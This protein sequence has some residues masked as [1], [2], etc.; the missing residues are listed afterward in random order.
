MSGII[1]IRAYARTSV[2][3]FYSV[4][5]TFT[6]EI[7]VGCPN[8]PTLTDLDGNTYQTVQIGT[9]C[10]TQSNLK[11]SKYRNG[12]NIP[13]GLSNSAWQN[14]T[15]GAY[16][17]YDN[18]PV[19]DGLYG[20][21]YNHFAV[22]DLRGL[23]PV[24]WHVPT[25]GDWTTLENFLGGSVVAGGSLKSTATL[26]IP[27][28]WNPPNT[29]S[30]NLVGFMAKPGGF[31]HI[32]A[33]F[34]ALGQDG[35]WWSST[36]TGTNASA[37]RLSNNNYNSFLNA[38][39]RTFGFSVRCLRDTL[40]TFGSNLQ[41][42]TIN[43]TAHLNITTTSALTGGLIVWDGGTPI[44][45]RGVVYD[46]MQNS[47]ISNFVT[48]VGS[49]MGLF[50]N[51]LTGLIPSKQYYYRAF[52]T[53]SLGTSYG[54]QIQFETNDLAVGMSY[55]GGI[56]FYLDTVNRYGLMCAPSDQGYFRWGCYGT[57]INNTSSSIGSGATNTTSIVTNCSQ[58]PIAASI[59]SDLVLNGY[60][61]W[62]LPSH[63]ELEM[64]Y[65]RLHQQGIG[66][67]SNTAYYWSSTQISPEY[68]ATVAFNNS[69]GN[70]YK[71]AT[72]SVR[73]VR[74]FFY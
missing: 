40:A 67:F 24:G 32:Y 31:N 63:D 6:P 29:G 74:T 64:M 1:Y 13:T 19:N 69:G 11:V 58:R 21:L 30:T 62:Y 48:N 20:K 33:Y 51:I 52:G 2:G 8:L 45:T 9:Q 50:T 56:V 54:N 25:D 16:A 59:C 46:T 44:V 34:G 10:W 28:G 49:G 26:P 14:S 72:N 55:E 42:P 61:D 23:C 12:D 70:T 15:A 57:N 68:A 38:N 36:L 5:R 43:T 7:G 3:V 37:L 17:I 65:L 35:Y 39:E 4:E 53:N 71:Q 73:A 60:S 66:N 47:I 18:N 22:T 27:G 41:L